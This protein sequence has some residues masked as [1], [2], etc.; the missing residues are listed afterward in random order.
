[1]STSHGNQQ[2]EQLPFENWGDR[3]RRLH[4]QERKRNGGPLLVLV[5]TMK[6]A[7]RRTQHKRA[8]QSPPGGDRLLVRRMVRGKERR[9]IR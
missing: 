3:V 4:M 6:R 1:M 2:T 8:S 5:P 7:E 9:G